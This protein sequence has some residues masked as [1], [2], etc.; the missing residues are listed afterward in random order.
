MTRHQTGSA[1]RW[2]AA[3]VALLGTGLG[4]LLGVFFGWALSVTL[5]ED[6]LTDFNVPY[7]ALIVIVLIG[8]LGGVLAAVR[9]GWRAA[10]LDVLRAIASE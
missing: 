1:I 5:R 7:T 6:G 2:E 3:I 4:A 10:H 9:P 8:A